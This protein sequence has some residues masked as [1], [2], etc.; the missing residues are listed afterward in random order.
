MSEPDRARARRL[1]AESLARG[2]AVGWFDLLYLEA[3]GE[4]AQIPWADQRV[5]PNLAQWLGAATWR[6]TGAGR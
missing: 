2:D 1:A 3:S 6:G 4:A 5:N